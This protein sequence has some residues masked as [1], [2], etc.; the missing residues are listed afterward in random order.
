MCHNNYR[1]AIFQ[2][3]QCFVDGKI[4]TIFCVNIRTC[5]S[6]NGQTNRLVNHMHP[7]KTNTE[8]TCDIMIQ[9]F[10]RFGKNKRTICGHLVFMLMQ[11]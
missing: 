1:T 4:P 6:K 8:F 3:A 2:L 11:I 5:R 9:H 7:R 10:C